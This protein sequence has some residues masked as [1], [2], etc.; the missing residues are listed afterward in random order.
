MAKLNIV[1]YPSEHLRAESEYVTVFDDEVRKLIDDMA[2]TMYA[3]SGAGLAANQVGV[4]KRIAVIDVDYHR[5][6]PNL[7][8]IVNPEIGAREGEISTE[9]GCLSFPDVREEISRWARVVVVAQDRKGEEF[10]LEA[11]GFL[12]VA[13]QHEIDHLDGLLIIDH[14]SSLKKDLIHRQMTRKK[15]PRQ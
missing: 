11:E 12:G 2:E 8:V 13:L 15:A 14:I 1:T 4:Q 10:Q 5:G 7:I 3:A 6:E 9:E